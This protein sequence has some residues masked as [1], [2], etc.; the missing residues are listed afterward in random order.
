MAVEINCSDSFC[1]ATWWQSKYK[2]LRA[3]FMAMGQIN[4]R[5]IK[6]ILKQRQRI[7]SVCNDGLVLTQ[8]PHDAD[9][10][11]KFKQIKDLLAAECLIQ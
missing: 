2:T 9:V 3:A 7:F 10:A 5:K 1:T 8:A 6:E 11:A 4:R